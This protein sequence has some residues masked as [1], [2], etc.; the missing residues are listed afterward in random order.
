MSWRHQLEAVLCAILLLASMLLVAVRSLVVSSAS[1]GVKFG[2]LTDQVRS[3]RSNSRNTMSRAKDPKLT[4]RLSQNPPDLEPPTDLGSPLGRGT[5]LRPFA[6]RSRLLVA[7][8]PNVTDL[9][10]RQAGHLAASQRLSRR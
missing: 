10:T 8:L 5:C 1:G 7:F 2:V 4:P 3:D 9:T 6:R